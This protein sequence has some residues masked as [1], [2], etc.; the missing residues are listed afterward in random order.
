MIHDAIS[1]LATFYD[2]DVDKWL[3]TSFLTLRDDNLARYRAENLILELGPLFES[4]CAVV[5]VRT[6]PD[7]GSWSA[8]YCIVGEIVLH[9]YIHAD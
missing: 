7:V 1:G 6:H 9:R 2:Y 5:I 4:D 8:R 3:W